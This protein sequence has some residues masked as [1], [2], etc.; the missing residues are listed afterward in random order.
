MHPQNAHQYQGIGEDTGHHQ[1][2]PTHPPSTFNR[3]R[4]LRALYY[5]KFRDFLVLWGGYDS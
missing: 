4:Y 1:Q 5:F 3:S 2:S